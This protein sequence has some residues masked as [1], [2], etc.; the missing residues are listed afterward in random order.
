MRRDLYE[1]IQSDPD[2]KKFIREQPHW[3]RKLSRNPSQIENMQIEMLN[4][5]KKT[6][7][8]KV[9]GLSQSLQLVEMMMGMMGSMMKQD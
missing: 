5:Y 1:Y 7:P 9:S 4:F 2:L 6:I 8:H 3:Y